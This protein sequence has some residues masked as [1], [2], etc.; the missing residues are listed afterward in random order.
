[1]STSSGLSG[2]NVVTVPGGLNWDCPYCAWRS[3]NGE[4]EVSPFPRNSLEKNV[5]V[6]TVVV[7]SLWMHIKLKKVS[8]CY[9]EC[10]IILFLFAVVFTCIDVW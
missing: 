4:S 2:D 6:M 8:Y 5:A 1:M 9:E 3:T 7:G 10:K